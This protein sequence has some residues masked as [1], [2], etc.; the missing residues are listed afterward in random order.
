MNLKSI[1]VISL[2]LIMSGCSWLCPDQPILNGC[3]TFTIIYPSRNDTL[4][5][6]EQILK[7]NLKHEGICNG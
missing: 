7:H 1:T 2:S 3:E 5:T 6:K 4:Q